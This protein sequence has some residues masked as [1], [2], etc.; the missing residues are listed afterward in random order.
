MVVACI[1]LQLGKC[2]VVS[3]QVVTDR[4]DAY[5]QLDCH[6]PFVEATACVTSV[7]SI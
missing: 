5:L 6:G 2:G 1:R 3:K 4:H 7:K